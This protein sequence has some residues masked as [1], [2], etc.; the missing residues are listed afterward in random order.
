[1]KEI[2]K[3]GK[4][5]FIIC[6]VAGFALAGTN[7]LTE[8]KIT[9]QKL[10]AENI[11]LKEV[12]PIA[13]CFE[14][15]DIFPKNGFDEK[16]NIVGYVLKVTASGYSSQI[17]ALVGIDEDFK[18]TGVKILSQNETPGLGTKISEENFL[19]QFTGKISEKILLKKDSKVGEIDGV[20]SATISSRA[21]TNGIREKINEFLKEKT[22][23]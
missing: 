9:S 12:L 2:T 4:Y 19:S 6:A 1:M 17:E 21:I 10:K 14:T 18:I 5:L 3:L 20:T 22:A 13:S 11:A 16:N 8:K 15:K 23:K 7:Y